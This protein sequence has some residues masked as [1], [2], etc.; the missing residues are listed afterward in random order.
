MTITGDNFILQ[1]NQPNS[2]RA[3]TLVYDT[4]GVPRISASN[5]E[6]EGIFSTAPGSVWLTQ[7]NDIKSYADDVA[8]D[9][10]TAAEQNAQGFADTAEQNAKDAAQGYADA[11]QAAAESTAQGYANT[12]EGNAKSYTDTRETIIKAYADSVGSNSVT[13]AENYFNNIVYGE[14]GSASSPATGSILDLING[15]DNDYTSIYN[16][17]NT[18]NN[19]IVSQINSLTGHLTDLGYLTEAL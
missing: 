2:N 1:G 12:A 18:G 7:K 15:L 8:Q 3:L 19:S 17:I 6:I 11:A 14:G 16:Q 9:A 10:Q 5:L 13:S 4:N